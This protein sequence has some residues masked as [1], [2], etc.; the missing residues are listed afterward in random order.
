MGLPSSRELNGCGDK[1]GG[2]GRF[3]DGLRGGG[4]MENEAGDD[5]E[6]EIEGGSVGLSVMVALF[7]SSCSRI[8]ILTLGR[9]C[10]MR[11]WFWRY[12]L[13]SAH[14]QTT[15]LLFSRRSST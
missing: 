1:D 13:I 8:Y 2:G 10:S 4:E 14:R 3:V 5:D 11:T 7:L 6:V 9:G 15:D 12:F